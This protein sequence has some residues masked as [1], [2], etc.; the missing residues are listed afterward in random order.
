MKATLGRL[1][2]ITDTVIQDR[3]GHVELARLAIAGGADT[4]QFRDKSLGAREAIEIASAIRDLCRDSHVTLI[5]N[6]RVD[7]AMAV[8]AEGVHLGQRDLPIAD[9]RSLLG[10]SKLIGGTAANLDEARQVE[11]DGADYVGFGHIYPTTSKHKP[12][13]PKGAALLRRVCTAVGIPVIGIGG[14]DVPNLGPVVDAGA[15]GVAVIGAVCKTPDPAA[16][17]ARLA[18]ELQSNLE[19]G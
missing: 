3:Y 8:D 10:P 16:A 15:W 7:I 17:A 14:I 19:G 6:D 4:I 2:V 9:A 5:I 1:H 13:E 12:G 18:A 11:R